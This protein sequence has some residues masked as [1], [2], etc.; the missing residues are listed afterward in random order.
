[1]RHRFFLVPALLTVALVGGCF[2]SNLQP[3]GGTG[4]GGWINTDGAGMETACDP[5]AAKPITLG[6]IVGV[7]EDA[8]GTLYVDAANGIFVSANGELDRQHVTGT[9]SSGSNQFLFTFEPVGADASS[10]RNLLVNTQGAIAVAMALGPATSKAFLGQSDGGASSNPGVEALTLV[11]PAVVAGMN[12]VNTPNVIDYLADISNGDVLLATLPLNDDP[13]AI[14]GGLSIFY[15][16]PD[17]VAQR[18]ITSFAESL[19]GGGA[20]S[21]FVG[22]STYILSFGMIVGPDS[23]PFGDFTLEGLAPG[24]GAQLGTTLRA[25]TPTSLPAGLSFTCLP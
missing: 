3:T 25:P 4:G 20:V 15:G 23:G 6:A 14:A 16:P 18:S 13:H 10:A 11:D 21:F 2:R 9:G 5:L 1:M 19:S 7:G 17:A 24:G 12:V 8:A 22:G